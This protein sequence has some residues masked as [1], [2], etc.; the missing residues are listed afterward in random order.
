M[1]GIWLATTRLDFKRSGAHESGLYFVVVVA[2][3]YCYFV[4]VVVVA[5]DEG[6]WLATLKVSFPAHFCRSFCFPPYRCII[7]YFCFSAF[8][9]LLL[10]YIISLFLIIFIFLFL[11]HFA[12]AGKFNLI[13]NALAKDFQIDFD[14][15]MLMS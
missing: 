14:P 5:A 3:C 7:F 1:A 6:F 8:L 4:V 12:H 2:C 11:W 10:L 13:F 9:Y 15:T